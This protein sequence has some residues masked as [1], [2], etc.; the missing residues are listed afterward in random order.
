MPD[1][2]H[3]LFFMDDDEDDRSDMDDMSP[4]SIGRDSVLSD[5][6]HPT[7]LTTTRT[8]IVSLFLPC[9]VSSDPQPTPP[10]PPPLQTSQGGT[11]SSTSTPPIAA[12]KYQSPA[13]LSPASHH[14]PLS[15][16]HS[17]SSS[18]SATA[19]TSKAGAGAKHL[20][21]RRSVGAVEFKR[22][23][24]VSE[25]RGLRPDPSW[26]HLEASGLGNIGLQNAVNSMR[27]RMLKPVW[28]GSLGV[29]TK[30]WSEETKGNVV[31]K[32]ENERNCVPVFLTDEEVEGHYNQFCKQVLWK[33]FHY[34]LRDY[35]KGEAYEEQAWQQY[36]A[37]NQKFADVIAE[38]YQ[39]GDIVWIN[40]Y[41]LML[42]PAMVRK[43]L[44]DAIIGFFLHIPFPSSEIFRCLHVREDILE[45]MLGADMIGFQ[46]YPF[47]RHFLMTC[48]RLLAL[49][50]TPRGVQ[51]EDRVV[52]VMPIPIGIDLGALNEKRAHPEVAEIVASLK[53]RYAGMKVLIGRD[54][55]DYVKGV[56]QKMLAFERFLKEYPEWVGRVVLI[57]V[58]LSTTE[59]NENECRVSDVVARINSRYGTIE[60]APVVYLHQDISFSHYLALWTIADACVITSL[61]DGMNLTSHEYVVCQEQNHGPL[62]ISEFAGTYGSFGAAL[63]VNPWDVREVSEAIN[64]ALNMSDEEKDFRWKELYSHVIGNT[65]QTYV[66]TYTAELV[67]AHEEVT[68]T[69][70]TSIPPLPEDLVLAEYA[71]SRK[72]VFFLDQ[73]GTIMNFNKH[74]STTLL[75]SRIPTQ[76]VVD[77]IRK[78]ASDPR[79]IVY[80]MSGRCKAEMQDFNGIPNVGLCAE[81][82]C[83]LKYANRN[84]WETMLPDHDLSWRKQVME[85]FEYYTDRTPGSYI[86]QKE[87]GMVW[88]YGHA[89]MNFGSWQAAE[90]QNHLEQA[91]T[92]SFAIHVLGKKRSLEVMPR[93]CNKGTVI[94]RVLE[95]H[96]GRGTQNR[97]ANHRNS[98]G[99]ASGTGSLGAADGAKA[100]KCRS[101]SGADS[102]SPGEGCVFPAH[103][104][105]V[106]EDGLIADAM[107]R[108]PAS[109][110]G[111]A[112][113]DSCSGTQPTKERID[114]CFCV[115]DDRADEYMF[116]YLRRLEMHS[117]TKELRSEPPTPFDELRNFGLGLNVT[118][119]PASVQQRVGNTTAPGPPATTTPGSVGS[120]DGDRFSPN[121]SPIESPAS[122]TL[123]HVG[124]H[125]LGSKAHPYLQ[126]QNKQQQQNQHSG[127][128]NT[129]HLP[130]S[131]V[132]AISTLPNSFELEMPAGRGSPSPAAGTTAT[133]TASAQK[134]PQSQLHRGHVFSPTTTATMMQAATT[135]TTSL[136]STSTSSPTTPGSRGRRCVITATVGKKSSA[137]KWYMSAPQEVLGL[138]ESFVRCGVTHKG[139]RSTVPQ[140]EVV[141]AE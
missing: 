43:L 86:E 137:A 52:A 16:G 127:H 54:K 53:E 113:A 18:S 141:E 116:E 7:L 81:N 28:I 34:Q 124:Y 97:R 8:I 121:A 15:A 5:A 44:P 49:E 102:T 109:M 85:I 93:N 118:S 47:M 128:N 10:P 51:L 88:H 90:C 75:S 25:S 24:K 19:T 87:I 117:N 82:G 98:L 95:H 12:R 71:Q 100:A 32:M 17:S 69:V 135:T 45:G 21:R 59:A 140:M 40:D 110:A 115:G 36:V 14:P 57:Q 133:T 23:R 1:H 138:L 6:A 58:A 105:Q 92:T 30:G 63:R 46:T 60:H 68:R 67:K 96:Q 26:W 83:F 91:L 48:T 65:A 35:P 130:D 55:N 50:S 114:F 77:V 66:E 76:R 125:E 94:R 103:D 42:V 123:P 84:S 108:E 134:Q 70:S 80:I 119:P 139:G 33:P 62:I 64:E 74:S 129:S 22:Q 38:T 27:R 131:V 61:R 132:A 39:P 13:T 126:H 37:V 89:D 29:S 9:T 111:A 11:T 107:T 101:V 136:T 72:R 106:S 56:R 41:H 122:A 20:E 3:S 31:S 104:R 78:L 79:N 73:D 2:S 4:S 99:F 120:H 112:A